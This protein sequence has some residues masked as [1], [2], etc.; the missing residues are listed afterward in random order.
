MSFSRINKEE[1]KT[2][3]LGFIV[4]RFEDKLYVTSVEKEK[5]L[6]PGNAI[7]SL[8]NIPVPKLV[9][10]HQRELMETKPER[11]DWTKIIPRYTT[12]EIMNTKGKRQK[13]LLQI[14]EKSPYIPEH[15]I[16]KIN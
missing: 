15:S 12:A 16:K 10:K 9:Q 14:F 2:F 5:R 7:V 13:I 6:N 1:Q 8:D 11:E 4:R 3:D